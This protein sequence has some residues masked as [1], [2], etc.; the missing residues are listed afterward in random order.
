MADEKTGP[1]VISGVGTMSDLLIQARPASFATYRSM[2]KDPAIALGRSMISALIAAGEWSVDADD[3]VSD[4]MVRLVTDSVVSLRDS[5]VGQCVFGGIDFGW[6]GFEVIFGTNDSGEVIVSRV[7]HLL[8]ELTQ[9]LI[10]PGGAFRGYRQKGVNGSSIDLDEHEVLHVAFRVEGTYW[11]GEPLL[12]NARDAWNK[13]RE[14]DAGASRYD[15][16]V[17][18]SHFVVKYPVGKGTYN[19]VDMDNAEIAKA[20]LRALESSGSVAIPMEEAEFETG[21]DGGDRGRWQISILE[22]KSQRQVG[23]KERLTYLDSQKVMALLVPPRAILEG[24]FGTKAEA[25]VHAEASLKNLESIDKT[26]ADAVTKQI[27]SMVM[28]ANYGPEM[29]HKVRI[30]PAPLTDAA[31][32]TLLTIYQT[33]LTNPQGM[34][35]EFGTIDTD[36]LKDRLKIPKSIEVA[37]ADAVDGLNELDAPGATAEELSIVAGFIPRTERGKF[38]YDATGLTAYFGAELGQADEA[39][40]RAMKLA[41]NGAYD[42]A[43]SVLFSIPRPRELKAHVAVQRRTSQ[44]LEKIIRMEYRANGAK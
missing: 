16:K 41:K 26:I 30:V 22:D 4:D 43:R 34:A 31:L 18:G 11:Y 17:A 44:M 35:E 37:T 20:I 19:G 38:T 2:R 15:K 14:T 10:T 28:A 7:K 23:F 39:F 3:D 8:P 36:A 29:A 5:I 12:E 9:I 6:C 33:I 42:S 21:G 27:V 25:G 1:Q 13:A 40:G 32:S 24:Q